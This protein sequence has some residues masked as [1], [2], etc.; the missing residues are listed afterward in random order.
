[1]GPDKDVIFNYNFSIARRPSGPG[2][3]VCDYRCP[4]ADRAVISDRDVGGMDLVNIYKLAN[5]DVASDNNTARPLQPRSQTES[6][7]GQKSYPTR[8]PAKQRR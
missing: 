6:S 7:G 5:P 2:V 8:K 3:K 1:M 4:Q